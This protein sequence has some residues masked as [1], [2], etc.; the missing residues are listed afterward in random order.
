MP[1]PTPCS[2]NGHFILTQFRIIVLLF[3]YSYIIDPLDF[4][5]STILWITIN[6]NFSW[7]RCAHRTEARATKKVAPIYRMVDKF[8]LHSM[9]WHTNVIWAKEK[10]TPPLVDFT[11]KTHIA[12][13]YNS[14]LPKPH[15]NSLVSSDGSLKLS[16]HP[17]TAARLTGSSEERSTSQ[18]SQGGTMANS[19]SKTLVPQR[20]APAANKK[21]RFNGRYP[22]LKSTSRPTARSQK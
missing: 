22:S 4:G 12:S 21:A 19:N 1:L 7:N 5:P 15:V 13:L 11:L 16:D 8:F 3:A 2:L 9:R 20:I 18:R 6:K 14:K 10:Y 17:A